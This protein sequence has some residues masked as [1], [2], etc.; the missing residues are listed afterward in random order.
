M[1]NVFEAMKHHNEE[2]ECFRVDVVQEVVKDVREEEWDHEIELFHLQLDD[3]QEKET[4]K[5]E[6]E[7]IVMEEVKANPPELKELPPKWKYVCLGGDSKKP[8]IISSLLTPLEEEDLLKE[9][10]TD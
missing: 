4:P 9:V 3:G 10:E 7:V 2:L 1:F 8:I 5:V 6:E